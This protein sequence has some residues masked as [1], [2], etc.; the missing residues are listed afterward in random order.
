V[1]VDFQDEMETDSTTKTWMYN[2]MVPPDKNHGAIDIGYWWDTASP[3]RTTRAPRT[4]AQQ[5]GI[6]SSYVMR[7][8]FCAR[9]TTRRDQ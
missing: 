3:A 4:S 1:W 8:R 7:K 9:A 2:G 6:C 5:C